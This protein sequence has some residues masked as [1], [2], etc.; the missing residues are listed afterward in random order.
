[1]DDFE[2]IFEHGFVADATPA[3]AQ[4]DPVPDVQVDQPAPA[5]EQPPVVADPPQPDPAPAD[6][7]REDNGRFAPVSALQEERQKRQELERRLAL[8]E[9][10]KPQPQAE[11]PRAP[12]P[13][14]DPQGFAA[15][16]RQQTQ[17]SMLEMRFQ[18]SHEM[19]KTQ[20]GPDVVEQARV[21]A[22]EKA[23]KDPAFDLAMGQQ[24][25]PLAWVVQQHK[26]DALLQQIGEDPDE[27]V[28]RRYAELTA[29]TQPAPIAA[30]PA[31][32]PAATPQPVPVPAPPPRSLVSEPAAGG[33]A[34]KDI[35]TGGMTALDSVFPK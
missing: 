25:H 6:P 8:L 19:A 4:P 31:A 32:V 15:F 9:A 34:I 16:Q 7:I 5:V 2:K 1:M 28:R 12:D 27:Y 24:A 26:R 17:Q 10:P 18:M 14:D 11:Q 22:S 35:P 30:V 13:Y 20:F 33:A 29:G 23:A 21:W 3:P